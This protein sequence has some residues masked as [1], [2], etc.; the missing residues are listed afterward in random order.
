MFSAMNWC[1]LNR[2]TQQKR[3][4]LGSG[5]NDLFYRTTAGPFQFFAAG[6]LASNIL[7]RFLRGNY[8]SI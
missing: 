1:G 5:A 3:L 2:K 7:V 8:L 6:I 4:K